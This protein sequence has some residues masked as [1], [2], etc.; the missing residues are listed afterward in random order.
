MRLFT[1]NEWLIILVASLLAISAGW[2]L[3]DVIAI[4]GLY[5]C[6][7]LSFMVAVPLIVLEK[8]SLVRVRS[9]FQFYAGCFS[10]LASTASLYYFSWN[11]PGIHD[12]RA[13][14]ELL[15]IPALALWVVLMV[16]SAVMFEKAKNRKGE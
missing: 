9:G 13:Y 6:G 4:Q 12:E 11:R 15:Y 3:R 16:I 7:L 8:W 2:V 5:C 1:R 10:G 14:E